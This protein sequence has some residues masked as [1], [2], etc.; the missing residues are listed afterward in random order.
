MMLCCNS[1]MLSILASSLIT[2]NLNLLAC[3]FVLFFKPVDSYI[4]DC[5]DGKWSLCVYQAKD[6]LCISM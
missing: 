5:T 4:F 3:M 6:S 2:L 1:S